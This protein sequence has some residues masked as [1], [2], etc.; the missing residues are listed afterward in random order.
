MEEYMLLKGSDS[1][2]AVTDDGGGCDLLGVAAAVAEATE[3]T[4]NINFALR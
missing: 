2:G 1:Q 3:K 4:V